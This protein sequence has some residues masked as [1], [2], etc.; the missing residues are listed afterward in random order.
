MITPSYFDTCNSGSSFLLLLLSLSLPISLE[1]WWWGTASLRSL[2]QKTPRRHYHLF[3]HTQSRHS[4]GS[5][6]NHL[7][8]SLLHFTISACSTWWWRCNRSTC[9]FLWVWK[10]HKHWGCRKHQIHNLVMRHSRYGSWN[11]SQGLV[12]H[13][14][15]PLRRNY[16]RAGFQN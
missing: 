8:L 15:I 3:H 5:L 12:H 4:C 10:A 16:E 11:T 7:P 2:R 6:F 14:L 13:Q 9:R 1:I